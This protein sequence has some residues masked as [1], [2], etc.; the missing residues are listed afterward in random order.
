MLASE[1]EKNREGQWCESQPKR[2]KNLRPTLLWKFQGRPYNFSRIL[3]VGP[4]NRDNK[5]R[6]LC[7]YRAKVTFQSS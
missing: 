1:A 3:D 7:S 2:K 6:F 5:R 4:L